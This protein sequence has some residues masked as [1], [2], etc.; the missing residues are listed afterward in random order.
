M[1]RW[2]IALALLAAP[3]SA[4]SEARQSGEKMAVSFES[5]LELEVVVRDGKGETTRLLNLNRRE[6]FTQTR[7][8]AKTLKIDCLSSSLQKSGTDTP[9]E[10]KPTPLAGHA[11]FAT[12]TEAGWTVKDKEGGA[13]PNEGQNL[14][15]WNDVTQLLPAG[16]AE[17]KQGDKWSVEAKDLMA[18]ILPAAMREATGK[19]E[20]ACESSEG[21]KANI[22]FSGQISGK[23]KD[24]GATVMTLAVKTGRLIYDFGKKKPAS[25]MLQGYFEAITDMVDVVR[26]PGTGGNVNN[27][28]ERRKVGEI[29]VKSHK[30]DA[31]ITFE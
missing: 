31:S 9:V 30:L 11:Y 1:M 3:L 22:V 13:A 7:M 21:G 29:S 12:R 20:C 4:P 15:A 25:L 27:E 6:K 17:P 28:E 2:L 26:K 8:D 14:G 5:A 23:G 16:G 24:E 10:E 19:L 18:L